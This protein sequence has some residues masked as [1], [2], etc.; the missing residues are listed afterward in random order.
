MVANQI[1]YPKR[2]DGL[3]GIELIWS[4]NDPDEQ[5]ALIRFLMTKYLYRANL[6]QAIKEETRQENLIPLRLSILTILADDESLYSDK[7]KE[8]YE[9]RK[10]AKANQL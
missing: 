8:L 10:Q 9:Q 7:L 1:T 2:W 4:I 3:T 5:E 6:I